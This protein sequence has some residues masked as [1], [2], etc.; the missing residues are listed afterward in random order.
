VPSLRCDGRRRDAIRRGLRRGAVGGLRRHRPWSCPRGGLWRRLVRVRLVGPSDGPSRCRRVSERCPRPTPCPRRSG[1]CPE[2]GWVVRRR[3]PGGDRAVRAE[4]LARLGR[5]DRGVVCVPVLPA[6]CRRTARAM[7]L[8]TP[9]HLRDRQS[10]SRAVPPGRRHPVSER[11]KR[12]PR[13]SAAY[14]RFPAPRL[15]RGL[16][17]AATRICPRTA[18]RRCPL[19]D[20]SRRALLVWRWHPPLGPAL[21]GRFV[22]PPIS[23]GVGRA[24]GGRLTVRGQRSSGHRHRTLSSVVRSR[25]GSEGV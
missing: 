6:V 5:R 21:E 3:R 8:L 16:L 24:R 9:V 7:R 15:R 22:S 13:A 23:L 20:S 11:R 1:S 25:C 14:R 12:A 10:C 4:R 19:A 17:W 18:T 2:R